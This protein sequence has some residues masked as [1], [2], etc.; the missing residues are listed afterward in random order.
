MIPWTKWSAGGGKTR[1]DLRQVSFADGLV[2]QRAGRNDWLFELD[3]LIDWSG[4][5]R[6]LSG[7]YASNEGRPSYSLLT[8][9]R[10]LLL[11]QWYGLSDPA[12]RPEKRPM[13]PQSRSAK[14][15]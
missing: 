2:T 4:I 12:I 5:E 15:S 3:T 6:V 13:P 11:Q 10:I 9:F 14:L 8:V 1:R 7:V